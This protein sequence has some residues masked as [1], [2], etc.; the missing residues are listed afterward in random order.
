I[1]PGVVQLEAGVA[2]E[3]LDRL[4]D[5]LSIF[6]KRSL[7]VRAGSRCLVK[8]DLALLGRRA[9]IALVG[10]DSLAGDRLRE[11][12]PL[13]HLCLVDPLRSDLTTPF[14][15]GTIFVKG[16]RADAAIREFDR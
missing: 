6:L 11:L 1:A 5:R 9:V 12:V 8:P 16:G 2:D 7:Y 15:C 10:K 14:G 3:A 13:H 4:Q